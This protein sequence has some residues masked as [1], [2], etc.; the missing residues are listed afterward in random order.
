M[1]AA[2]A[3]SSPEDLRQP[4]TLFPRTV[5]DFLAHAVDDDAVPEIPAARTESS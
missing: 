2:L 5:D 1:Q 4:A 3:A